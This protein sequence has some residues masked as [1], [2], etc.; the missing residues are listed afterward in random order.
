MKVDR[1]MDRSLG[2]KFQKFI[3]LAHTQLVKA[4]HLTNLAGFSLT[5]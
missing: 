4:S 5:V 1:W 3:A 2:G